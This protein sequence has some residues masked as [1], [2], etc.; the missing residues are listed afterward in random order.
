MVSTRIPSLE[1]GAGRIVPGAVMF[2]AP[3]CGAALSAVTGCW[4]RR[5]DRD[6]KDYL[7]LKAELE[8]NEVR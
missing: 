7:E 1:G 5:G 8:K 6:R 2:R 3:V 4:S